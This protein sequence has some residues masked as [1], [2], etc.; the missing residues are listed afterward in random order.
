MMIFSNGSYYGLE[1][2]ISILQ[3]FAIWSGLKVNPEKCELFSAGVPSF[4]LD[5]MQQL[6]GFQAF[7]LSLLVNS[8]LLSLSHYW[9]RVFPLP[10]GI[11]K[12]IQQI[13]AFF[14]WR[15]DT[16]AKVAWSEITYPKSEGGLG[17]KDL[18]MWNKALVFRLL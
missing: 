13:C 4:T 7:R 15:A 12:R 18:K 10:L 5:K 1:V 9:M 8:V 11:I 3:K 6:S 2:I 16:K 14:L 17:L